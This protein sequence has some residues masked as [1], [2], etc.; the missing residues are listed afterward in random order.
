MLVFPLCL[1]LELDTWIGVCQFVYMYIEYTYELNLALNSVEY[2]YIDYTSQ[3][4]QGRS[5][6]RMWRRC[7]CKYQW[8]PVWVCLI[9]YQQDY[10]TIWKGKWPF[11]W[12]AEEC[13]VNYEPIQIKDEVEY[14]HIRSLRIWVAQLVEARRIFSMKLHLYSGRLTV[15]LSNWKLCE[16]CFLILYYPSSL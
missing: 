12:M 16:H 8:E 13:G 15:V 6:V 10:T 2:M 14:H 3:W 9:C 1:I 7:D 4:R 5:K 11:K